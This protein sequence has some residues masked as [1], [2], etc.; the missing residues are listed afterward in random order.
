MKTKP[1][2]QSPRL[3]PDRKSAKEV[4]RE[5]THSALNDP[6]PGEPD[7]DY[8]PTPGLPRPLEFGRPDY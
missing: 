4:R 8:L 2:A 3:Q 5:S 1:N 7:H 6:L